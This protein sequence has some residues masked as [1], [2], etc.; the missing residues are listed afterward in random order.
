MNFHP[1]LSL[2]KNTSFLLCLLAGFLVIPSA[3]QESG[4]AAAACHARVTANDVVVADH[5]RR[6]EAF[7]VLPDG[8]LPHP[9]QWPYFA[10]SDTPLG[11]AHTRDGSGYLFF[12]SD[13]GCHLNC[14]GKTPRYGS[15][16]V[17]TGTLD[18]PLGEPLGD[19]NPPVTEFVFPV[20]RNLPANID[21]VGGGPVYRVPDG[22][23]GAGDLII[24]YHAERPAS[25]FWSWL[26]LARSTDEGVTWTDLGLIIG[27]THAYSA[28]GW[29][30]IGDGNLVVVNDPKTAQKYFYIYFPQGC[31]LNSTTPCSDFA[32]LSVARASYDEVLT[33]SM[34]GASV[35]GLFQKY[36]KGQWNQPGLDGKASEL[37]PA[38]TGQT[39][40]DPQIYWSSFRKR[41]IAIL[42]NG[43]YTAYGE[44]LDGLHWPAMQ[45]LIGKNP[46]TATYAYSNA[47]GLGEN[48]AILGSTFYS[49]YTDWAL[50][51]SWQPAAIKR[52]T[53]SVEQCGPG[54]TPATLK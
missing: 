42:N 38:V 13:G 4:N 23:P 9:G 50:G 25:P 52:L 43:Q 35:T 27:G 1:P 3:A 8:I 47:V 49:Y 16:T 7:H 14:G 11:V 21:Y 34:T 39:D 15:I 37:F 24:V 31:F 40:G 48:P 12:G 45:V 41:F 18:H 20:S 30:D 19:P 33:A 46:Q 36:F 28:Q 51:I 17:S 10:W 26:G 54:S 6:E 53:V 22:E 29:L 2:S 44:S 5:E 32:Y